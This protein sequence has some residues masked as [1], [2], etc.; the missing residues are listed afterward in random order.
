MRPTRP[1]ILTAAL[2]GAALL[3]AALY[4]DRAGAGDAAAAAAALT[5]STVQ[6]RQE[7]WGDEITANGG[8][9]AW[10]ESVVAAEIG[11]LAIASLEVDVGAAVVRG[12]LLARLD[13]EAVQAAVEQQRAAVEQAQARL[14]EAR[15]NGERARRLRASGAMSEQAVAQYLTAERSAA[16]ALKAARAGLVVEEVRLRQTRV[17][18]VDDGVISARS[19]TLGAVVPQ[20]GELFRLVRQGRLEWRAELTAEQLARVRPGQPARLQLSSGEAASGSVR[21]VAPTLDAASRKAIAYVDLPA[22]GPARAGMFARGQILSGERPATT[23]PRSALLL[24]DGSSYVFE[25]GPDLRVREHKVQA[26]RQRGDR[27]EVLGALPQGARF[28]ASGAA[29]LRA[30]D[31]VRVADAAAGGAR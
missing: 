4:P 31:P 7:R 17:E 16:A 11:G 25:V 8:V 9:Y 24:R 23:L 28:V 27:V 13:A 5:V 12:Q 14:E 6:A 19:A 30:G 10:Q 2:L 26:G 18:A 20:G 3:G 29:F 1:S 22:G 21:Q 15:A